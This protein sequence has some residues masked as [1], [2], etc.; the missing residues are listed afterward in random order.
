MASL[1]ESEG[2]LKAGRN[3]F[4]NGNAFIAATPEAPVSIGSFCAIGR[5][6]TIMP[7]NHDT[8]YAALQGSLYRTYF[9]T[10]HPGEVGPPSRERSKGGVQIGSDV[11][12]ADNVTILSGVTI[13]HGCCIGAGS[14]V[15]KSLLAYT[16]AAGSPCRRIRLRFP[17]EICAM[18]LE[19]AWWDWDDDRIKRNENF[20]RLALSTSDA[21]SIRAIC[22]P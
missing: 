10:P 20:F 7:L 19:L 14:I 22:V 4:H 16:V 17:E 15:T 13:G 5:N 18:L 11:W 21:A 6:V 8:N 1:I 3:S 9:G 2:P 12:I